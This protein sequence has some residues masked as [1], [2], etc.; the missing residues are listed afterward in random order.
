MGNSS[1]LIL[2]LAGF[3]SRLGDLATGIGLLNRLDDTDGNGLTHVT[4]GETT[5][6]W[7]LGEGLDAHG[8]GGDHANNGGIT[9][10]DLLG[11]VL[12]LL[13]GTA[14]D[15]LQ[16]L[17]ELAGNVGGVAI[18]NGRVAVSDLTGVVQDND[19]GVELLGLLGWVILGVGGNVAT[20][21][22][23]DGDVLHV[24]TN[25]V[26]GA[27]LGEGL[28]VHLDGLDLSGDVGWGEG[29]DHTGLDL[30][31]L[32]TANGD[33]SDTTDLV[34]ILEGKSEWLVIGTGWW[35]DGIQSLEHGLAGEFALLDLLAPA[36]VPAHVGGWLDHV[37][38]VPAGDGDEGDGL[39]VVA[40]LLDVVG[41]LTGDFLETLLRVW[42]L[43]GVHLV[44]TNDQLLDTKGEG[45]Q[46]VLTGLAILGNAS[47][48]LAN[49]GGN[50]QD[51]AIGLGGTRDHVLDE[52]T[53]TGCVDDGD[54][55]LVGLEL[56]QGNVD[57]DSTLTLGLEVVK[58]PGIL[59]RSLTHLGGLLL[60][61]LN[62]TLVDTSALVD[63][64][65]SGG[66]LTGI[67]VTDNDQV[68]V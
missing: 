68:Y 34:D 35:D 12:H 58:H 43:G 27:G 65:T 54:V 20:T 53:V 19:L 11:E 60:V 66:G 50:D 42:W 51:G 21:D 45:Q 30:A 40:D 57:G 4:D 37:I 61:L 56:P 5:E 47:L 64:V 26:T 31:S 23:L 49:T 32:D 44:D 55:V 62:G 67:Y 2:L 28:V 18:Q 8:L 52:I 3:G 39:G 13:A 25:V 33:C 48:E 9:R 1:G 38:T 16:E 36:L 41:D 24:E 63:Q 22:V 17:L 59:E 15:F 7:V 10:L 29:D 46:G 14:I 6:G